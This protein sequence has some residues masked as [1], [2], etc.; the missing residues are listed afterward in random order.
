MNEVILISMRQKAY[1]LGNFWSKFQ[2]NEKLNCYMKERGGNK[3]FALKRN[4]VII[5]ALVIM[6]AAAGYLN[7]EESKISERREVMLTDD[8][9]VADAFVSEVEEIL[10]LNEL[11]FWNNNDNI[12]TALLMDENFEIATE[13]IPSSEPGEAVFVNMSNDSSF[14]LQAK[15]DRE[16]TRSKQRDILTEIINNVNIEQEQKAQV[17][18]EMIEIQKRI[19][20]EAAAEAL[21]EA[22]GFKEA[23]VRIDSNTVDVIVSKEALTDAEIAQIEDIVRRKTGIEASNIRISPLKR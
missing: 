19:E 11:N 2:V 7:Y 21:I 14:F 10:E 6:I 17:A 8:G 20:K 12:G 15:L 1:I 16:Q 4:Q 9:R 3:M 22:K 18:N 23:F 13:E 5:T